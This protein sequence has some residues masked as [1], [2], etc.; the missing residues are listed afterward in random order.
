MHSSDRYDPTRDARFLGAA[1]RLGARELGSTWPNPAVG[2][3]IVD[4][5]EQWPIIVG[6]GNTRAGGRPHAETE[7]LD[8]A[9]ERARGATCY[10]SLEPCAHHGRTPPCAEVL[11]AAGIGRV[12]SALED[13]DPRVAG[14]GY[15]ILR[16]A[17]IAVESGLL[18]DEAR[19]VH[20]GHIMRVRDGRPF[21][22]LK[23]AVSRDGRIAGPGGAPVAITGP[24]ARAMSH[25]L[26]ATHDAIAVGIGT[27][28]ADDPELTCRLPGMAD[29]SPV[30]VVL[31]SRL[32]LPP[33]ARML[34]TLSLAP[35]WVLWSDGSAQRAGPLGDHGASLLECAGDPTGRLE[36]R[37]ALRVLAGEG[38][39]RLLVEGG[40]AV[41]ASLVKAGVVDEVV[42][43][44]GPI[45]IGPGGVPA[46]SGL[47]AVLSGG[48]YRRVDRTALG[49]D[50]M[51]RFVRRAP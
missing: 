46:G 47:A 30:R 37:A 32:R 48:A 17:G 38:I 40:A 49:E 6:R 9:G 27:A 42:V 34:G 36:I 25:M 39:T 4:A 15:E 14:N 2:A 3:L 50:V 12:V 24:R 31:D 19:V 7:A 18:A 22:T 20:A 1:I 29:R 45:D 41:A 35:V 11:V 8:Q 16:A 28:L 21:V 23:L 10:V 5:G 44:E 26:R 13:P 51:S 43:F 33:S